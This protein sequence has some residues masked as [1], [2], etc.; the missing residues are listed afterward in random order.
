MK[1]SNK[2]AWDDLVYN[3]LYPGVLGSM[4][5]DIAGFLRASQAFDWFAI[6]KVLIVVLYATDYLHLR[7]DL[8]P[9]RVASGEWA[10]LDAI[11]ALLFAAGSLSMSRENLVGLFVCLVI[12]TLLFFVYHC[13]SAW[14]R[15]LYYSGKAVVVAVALAGLLCSWA[16]GFV[17]GWYAVWTVGAV[18]VVYFFHVFVFIQLARR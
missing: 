1:L 5:Y 13:P 17:G 2:E 9:A 12:I 4:I 3:L 16:H 6:T 18:V 14:L 8:K 11:I 15:V 10:F 7:F